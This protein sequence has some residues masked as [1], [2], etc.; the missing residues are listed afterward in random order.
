MASHSYL[1]SVARRVAGPPETPRLRPP[2]SL[3]TVD[4]ADAVEGLDRVEHAA[5]LPGGASSAYPVPSAESLP[6]TPAR[7]R[8]VEPRPEPSSPL[9]VLWAQASAEPASLETGHARSSSPVLSVAQPEPAPRLQL[10]RSQPMSEPAPRSSPIEHETDAVSRGRAATSGDHGPRRPRESWSAG[11]V[12][13]PTAASSPSQTH[14]ELVSA[15]RIPPPVEAG[16]P[17]I[18]SPPQ[19]SAFAPAGEGTRHETGFSPPTEREPGRQLGASSDHESSPNVR[20]GTVEVV[21][22]TP[23]P[24]PGRA[25]TVVTPTPATDR[26]ARGYSSLLGLGQS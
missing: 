25:P 19:P 13:S 14:A 26:L 2:L 7:P 16:V 10:A 3:W 15:T 8:T 22:S 12:P 18:A 6:G 5:G 24:A 4:R 20:I 11:E 23:S 9:S 21:V 17:S 1:G